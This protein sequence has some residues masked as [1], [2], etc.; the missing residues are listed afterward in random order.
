MTVS[1]P[2]SHTTA[3]LLVATACLFLGSSFLVGPTP[4]LDHQGALTAAAYALFLALSLRLCPDDLK[5]HVLVI[6]WFVVIFFFIRLATFAL[7]PPETISCV[8]L[9]HLTASQISRGLIFLLAGTAALIA[10]L[11]LGNL[12]FRKTATDDAPEPGPSLPLVPILL[13]WL[14]ALAAAYYVSIVLGVTIFGPPEGWGSRSGWL[15]RIFDTDVALLLIVVWSATSLATG[16]SRPGLVLALLFVWLVVSIYLGSRGGPLRIF[17]LFGIAAIAIHGDPRV[18]MRRLLGI[19]VL[20]FVASA[21]VYPLSTLIRYTLGGVEMAT[22]QLASDW[23]RNHCPI[24][25]RPV[26]QTATQTFLWSNDV[27]VDTAK[28]LIP[29]T[30]RL[31]VVDYPLIILS[32][33]PDQAVIDRYLATGYALRNFANNMVPGEIF[34][35][36]DVMTSRV[37][38]M[39]YR[40]APESHI[41]QAFLSEPWTSWGYA[42][43]KGGWIGGMFILAAFA[44]VSQAGYRAL[45]LWIPASAR[46]YFLTTWLFIVTANG[47]LQLFGIDHWLTVAAHVFMALLTAMGFVWAGSFLAGRFGAVSSAFV[48]D[49]HRR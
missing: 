10:G 40:G 21:A 8:G 37:F 46:P 26:D 29:I 33:T 7:F 17:F 42:W 44:A 39:A 19:L 41:R 30:T 13:F 16:R 45:G 34:P 36:H 11:A 43:L 24:L 47:P 22:D 28:A 31:G 20:T 18:S 15:M 2:L 5:P 23:T 38:T 6:A 35:D 25:D 9:E 32:Q 3:H 1:K 49:R 48:L 14:A 4:L 12:P 27:V